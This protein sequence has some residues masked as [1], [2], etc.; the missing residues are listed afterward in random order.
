M[1]LTYRG[2]SYQTEPI[3]IATKKTNIIAKFRG[4]SYPLSQ[5]IEPV[6]DSPYPLKYR[7]ISYHKFPQ[8]SPAPRQ[9]LTP[10][11]LSIYKQILYQ[12]VQRARQLECNTLGLGYTAVL[13]KKKVGARPYPMCAYVQSL[14][15]YSQAVL[16]S[17]AV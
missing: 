12:T 16:E 8:I 15:R 1:K 2:V 9:R 7:G 11:L 13:E 17:I 6:N 14:D 4:L 3:A 5:S 10:L